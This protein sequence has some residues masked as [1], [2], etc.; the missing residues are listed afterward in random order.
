MPFET[1]DVVIAGGA[2]IGS[3]VAYFLATHPDFDGRVL[4]LERDPSYRDCATTRSVAS[5][6]HQ[7][8]TPENVRLSM[9]GTR[10]LR[11]AERLL[12]VDQVGPALSFTE[13]GYLFLATAGGAEALRHNHAVQRR[14]GA[15]VALLPAAALQQRFDWLSVDDLAAGSLGLSGEGWLDAHALLHGFKRKAQSL[16]VVYRTAT[17]SAFN[18]QGSRITGVSL[19]DG[20]QIGCG[21]AVNA[22]GT[23]A[24]ALAASAGIELPV[25]AR[26]RCVFHFRSPARLPGCGL[27]IDPTGVYFRPE[28]SGFIAG[29]APPADQDPDVLDP[30]DFDV[31]AS[32]FDDLIW[33]TLAHRVPGFEAL[34]LVSSWAGHYDVNLLDANAIVGPHPAVDNLLFANGFSGHGLQQSPGVG[35][36]LAEWIAEGG[37]RSLDLSAL[38][39]QRVIDGCPLQERAVV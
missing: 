16:G 10:F 20:T 5:I 38:G 12:A 14:E 8:S 6:R 13:A 7:F 2:V 28:G 21:W 29:V 19:A 9:A 31:D 33:P 4:V 35:R 3:A 36:A 37:W 23:G 15:D 32:V 22:A 18:R 17:V 11:H 30:A 34:R 1:F 26:K 39:W 25:R 27:V 24:A